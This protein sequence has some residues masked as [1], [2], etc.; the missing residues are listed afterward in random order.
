MNLSLQW[1]PQARKILERLERQI[2]DRII[3]KIDLAIEDPF[4]YLEHFEGASLYKLRVGDYRALIEID[5]RQKLMIIRCL[6]H[7]K[8]VYKR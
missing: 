4:H 2:A 5:F 8:K 1:D 7:R 6:D 3:E